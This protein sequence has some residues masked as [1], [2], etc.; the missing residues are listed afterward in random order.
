MTL[1]DSLRKMRMNHQRLEQKKESAPSAPQDYV[2]VSK[3][4]E[5]YSKLKEKGE[6]IKFLHDQNCS[7]VD[8][9]N[10]MSASVVTS[11]RDRTAEGD[12][13]HICD[14]VDELAVVYSSFHDFSFWK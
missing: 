12:E 2:H 4:N 3:V 10:E 11:K 14:C 6:E 8:K 7:L 5:A 1:R 13:R 9:I